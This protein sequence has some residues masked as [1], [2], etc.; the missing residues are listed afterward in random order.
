MNLNRTILIG[1]AIVGGFA[2]ILTGAVGE[3]MQSFIIG[4]I[5]GLL[6]GASFS[7][8][9][10]KLSTGSMKTLGSLGLLTLG[11]L[12]IGG[13][14]AVQSPTQND[15]D[16]VSARMLSNTGQNVQQWPDGSAQATATAP[17][18]AQI[19][20]GRIDYQGTSL[21]ALG[22]VGPKGI[23]FRN[24]GNLRADVIEMAFGEP[25]LSEDG[26]VL[27]PLVTLRVEGLE[28]EVTTVVDANTEQVALWVGVLEK[29]SADQRAAVIA[30]L[31]RDRVITEQTAGVLRELLGVV[32]TG[33][34]P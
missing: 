2:V 17:E 28:N 32:G 14:T 7:A 16:A 27:L 1:L 25:L 19:A 4:S 9:A 8:G 10:Q 5:F 13:C 33:V 20:E 31:E 26:S 30:A 3:E 18:S 15:L 22:A 21:S 12:V 6:G 24:P 29:I 11:S 23:N 34:L